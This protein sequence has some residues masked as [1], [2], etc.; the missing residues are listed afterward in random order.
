[1]ESPMATVKYS[2]LTKIFIMK[3]ILREDCLRITVSFYLI[4]SIIEVNLN[5][6]ELKEPEFT[7]RKK[8]LL[9]VSLS[10][11]ILPK[12]A[13]KKDKIIS[14]KDNSKAANGKKEYYFGMTE[15]VYTKEILK[16]V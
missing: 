4:A 1:M 14:L 2:I 12:I 6:R 5:Y 11:I 3:V 9:R 15:N 7:N 13:L 16:T 8:R 10:K